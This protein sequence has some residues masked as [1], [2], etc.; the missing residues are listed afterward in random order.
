[1]TNRIHN[2]IHDENGK[3]ICC[4][5]EEKIDKKTPPPLVHSED[6]GHHHSHDHSHDNEGSWKVYMPAIVSFVLLM[7]G[8]LMDYF[9]I[10]FFKDSLRLLWYIIAYI[11]VGLPVVKEAFEALRKGEVF[12]EFFLMSIATI[13]AF[14]IGEYPEG[15]A[16]MLFYAV[17]EL[18]QSAAVKKAKNN[19]KALLD[20]RPKIANALRGGKFIPINPNEVKIGETIQVKVGEKIPLDGQL[21]SKRGSFNTAAITGESKPQSVFFNESVLAGSINLDG[22]ID[23]KVTKLFNDSSVSR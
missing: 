18:F 9:N 2:H 21:L 22:V 6:D 4:S 3:Q 19:I 23:V 13:G 7:S 10:G 17:G 16:V 15:V 1:M 12:T 8:I 14:T 11:P 20:V 5:L